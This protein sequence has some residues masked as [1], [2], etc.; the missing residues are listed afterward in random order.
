MNVRDFVDDL[1][2]ANE[3][4]HRCDCP[5]CGGDKTFTVTNKNG[6]LVWN[7]YKAGCY[8]QGG[9]PTFLNAEDIRNKIKPKERVEEVW[10]RPEYIVPIRRHADIQQFIIRWA[11]ENMM[12]RPLYDAKEHRVVFPVYRDKTLVDGIGR[13]LAGRPPKWKRYGDSGLPYIYGSGPIAV[14]VEDAI[15][16]TVVGKINSYTGVALLGTSLQDA[17]KK[18]LTQYEKLVVALDPDALR[19]TLNIARD[20][21]A[22][23]SQVSVVKLGDDLKYQNPQDMQSLRLVSR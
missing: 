19:K 1:E 11:L 2:V 18:V 16:A 9:A 14:I 23:H 15:S 7:C 12:P 5:V 21:R 3:A 20:L 13:S 22:V 17:H 10:Q 4:T 8:V 6:M